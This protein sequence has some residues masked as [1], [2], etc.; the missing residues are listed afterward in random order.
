MISRRSRK[1]LSSISLMLQ[2]MTSQP[3]FR[4]GSASNIRVSLTASRTLL[5]II[6][7]RRL[8]RLRVCPVLPVRFLVVYQRLVVE[9]DI[10]R[11]D[12][13]PASWIERIFAL[14]ASMNL[15]V[16]LEKARDV[17]NF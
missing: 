8:T 13:I 17:S 14:L 1:K 12:H 7:V 3:Q 11:K 6:F 15:M 9:R 10:P 4:L 16:V 5:V 2:E